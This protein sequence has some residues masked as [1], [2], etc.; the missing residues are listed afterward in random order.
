MA[1]VTYVCGDDDDG[2]G[3]V[4]TVKRRDVAYAAMDVVVGGVSSVSLHFDFY[5]ARANRT[6]SAACRRCGS[7]KS[8]QQTN[9]RTRLRR[10]DHNGWP[11]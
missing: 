6:A 8:L 9:I 2:G 5:L 7:V 1:T 11:S 10:R 4:A 3:D